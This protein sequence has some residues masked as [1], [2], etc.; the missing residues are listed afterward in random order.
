MER[1]PLPR[2]A[3]VSPASPRTAGILPAFFDT[4]EEQYTKEGMQARCLRYKKGH[5]R[6]P[7]QGGLPAGVLAAPGQT[8]Y[9]ARGSPSVSGIIQVLRSRC[10]IKTIVASMD[11]RIVL[12][13]RMESCVRFLKNLNPVVR[14]IS[15][16]GI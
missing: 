13:G 8:G 15:V 6:S 10:P 12:T 3:G 11:T 5:Q 2:T 16:F 14:R 7:P 1:S 4:M 9:T